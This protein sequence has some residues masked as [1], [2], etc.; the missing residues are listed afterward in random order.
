MEAAVRPPV[1]P[2]THAGNQV[3]R[4]GALAAVGP[5]APGPVVTPGPAA[6]G[7]ASRGPAAPIPRA[8]PGP[9]AHAP[10]QLAID[11]PRLRA[12]HASL[13]AT[14]VDHS[15]VYVAPTWP[16]FVEASRLAPV[17]VLL[18]SGT[19][20][21]GDTAAGVLASRALR[22]ASALA[23]AGLTLAVLGTDTNLVGP[24]VASADRDRA[25]GTTRVRLQG[26]AGLVDGLDNVGPSVPD[27][28][29]DP[30]VLEVETMLVEPGDAPAASLER[31]AAVVDEVTAAAVAVQASR[32]QRHHRYQ[33]LFA[34]GLIFGAPS[35]SLCRAVLMSRPRSAKVLARRWGT[36]PGGILSPYVC[37]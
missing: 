4:G 5:A 19:Q 14:P 25:P 37:C 23:R 20:A 28:L 10:G 2:G 6:P 1:R 36:R 17:R 24:A 35:I 27:L 33:R 11:V 12:C 26:L 29:T 15:L 34:C 7:P 9:R 30:A 31:W 16:A 18:A 22:G 13:Q 8:A 3:G 21:G 32:R